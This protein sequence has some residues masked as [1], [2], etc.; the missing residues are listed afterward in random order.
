MNKRIWYILALSVL[1]AACTFTMMMG[2]SFARYQKEFNKTLTFEVASP[3]QLCLGTE[4]V[5]T[6]VPEDGEST[7]EII[8]RSFDPEWNPVQPGLEA[9]GEQR[10]QFA[11]ANGVSTEDFSSRDQQ[12]TLQ[13]ITTLG[14]T[15]Q[16]GTNGTIEAVE[17]WLRVPDDEGDGYTEY[18]GV[19]AQIDESTTLGQ[20]YGSGWVYTFYKDQ[21]TQ[22]ELTWTLRGGELEYVTLTLIIKGQLSEDSLL[23]PQVTGTLL[24]N[25]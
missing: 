5:E 4:K 21:D 14:T 11:V 24:D 15:V 12:F 16:T 19:A 25:T 3:A 1:L 6:I 9:S 13:V 22:T 18:A 10:V 7:E 8:V 23:W 20:K 2:V 17:C